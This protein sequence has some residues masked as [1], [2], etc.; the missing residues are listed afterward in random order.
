MTSSSPQK[1]KFFDLFDIAEEKLV[2]KRM[3]G[4]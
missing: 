3:E 4:K 2:D 1:S